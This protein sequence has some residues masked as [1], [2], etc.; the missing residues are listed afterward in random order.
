MF[1]LPLAFTVPAALASLVLLAALYVFLRI[2]PP[3]PL[4][5]IFPPL[6]LLLGIDRKDQTPARTPWPLLFLRLAI[7]AA[8]ILAMAGP[9]WN[10]ALIGGGAGPLLMIVDDGWPAAPSWD[11]RRTLIG[12]RL[13]AAARNNRLVA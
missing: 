6:R 9:I 12:A 8:A 1:G 3:R 5:T 7:A 10:P 11:Q 13:E 4:Q 2:T